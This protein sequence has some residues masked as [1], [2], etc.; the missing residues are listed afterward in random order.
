MEFPKKVRDAL[1]F[2]VKECKK[3]FGKDLVSII[4]FGSYARGNWKEYSDVDLLVIV[5]KKLPSFKERFK[6]LEDTTSKILE[7]YY[8]RF[9]PIIT[10]VDELD[11]KYLNPLILG[12][13]TGHKILFGKR[14]W[15]EYISKLK[16]TIEEF[17]PIYVEGEKEWKIKDLIK[18]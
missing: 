4:L 3:K 8:L 6:L 5:R 1:K 18:S 11:P 16:N 10:S 17:E 2:F 9:F 14:F 15:K 13:L 12:I 7:K